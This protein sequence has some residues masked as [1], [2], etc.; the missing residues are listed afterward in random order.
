MIELSKNDKRLCREY[1]QKGLEAEC[2]DF[3]KR[4][5]KT[6][7]AAIPITELNAPYQ[8]EN[9]RSVEGPWH[10]R[11][12]KLYKMMDR[13]DNHVADRYDHATGGHYLDIVEELYFDG[14]LSDKDI[15]KF[16][17]EVRNEI[18]QLKQFYKIT[19]KKKE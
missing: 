8:E 2:Q 7:S 14:W 12:I 1:I 3:I 19:L 4:L 9:G 15:E 18:D 11:Y 6:A 5:Q 13:F 16:D 10:K 17:E